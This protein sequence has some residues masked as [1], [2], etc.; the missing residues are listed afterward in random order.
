MTDPRKDKQRIQEAKGGLLEDPYRWVLDHAA[1]KQFRNDLQSRMLWIKGDPGKGKTMLLCGII[2]E[3]EKR[4]NT[5]LSFF[6]CQATEGPLNNATAVLR[7]LIYLLLMRQPLLV[8]HVR[9]E[10]E[11]LGENLF[12]GINVWVSLVKILTN[13]LADPTLNDAIFIV[14]ALDECITDR[15]KLLDF[16]IHS[17]STPSSGVKWIL[18]SR[19]WPEI[20]SQLEGTQK[21]RL[22]LEL[23]KDSVSKAVEMYIEYKVHQLASDRKYD[24]NTRN[25]V[26]KHLISSAD[27]TF[28]W[29]ALVC[30]EL[31]K[32]EV[33]RRHALSKLKS[34]PRGLDSLYGRMMEQIH[35]SEDVDRC[36]E[37]LAIAS[38]VYRPITL[39]EMKVLMGSPDDLQLD[40]LEE[41]IASCGSFLTILDRIIYFVHQSAKDYLLAKASD[42]ILPAGIT[43]QHQLLFLRSLEALSSTL[44][45]N[46]YSLSNPGFPIDRVSRPNPDPLASIRY[47]C[48]SWVDHLLESE[49]TKSG[50]RDVQADNAIYVF[51][52]T[53]YL[54][55]LESLSLLRSMSEGAITLQRLEIIAVS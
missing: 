17:T 10:Y 30:Q 27:G 44:R 1:F 5:L 2:D 29:A 34:F 55:W 46:I 45:R 16:I 53:K 50:G 23:N 35:H 47:S 12:Q 38:V 42:Q 14:D 54:Y 51:I 9:V 39:E 41:I 21:V 31:A 20:E 25:T 8:R 28:L 32:P 3:L 4:S 26:Q 33:A 13:I 24:E 37:V 15:H 18:S 6:F 11:L 43:Q 48:V 7:G 49:P 36:K 40:D 22:H 19:N 52:G